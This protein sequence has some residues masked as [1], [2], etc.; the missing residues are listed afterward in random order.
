M[1]QTMKLFFVT[2][3]NQ[4]ISTQEGCIH[5][6]WVSRRRDVC[7]HH[8]LTC[9]LL[10]PTQHLQAVFLWCVGF[11]EKLNVAESG[12][13]WGTKHAACAS[14]AS[15]SL[16]IWTTT[17]PVCALSI[18]VNNSGVIQ[19]QQEQL[20]KV[21]GLNGKDVTAVR[22]ESLGLRLKKHT[23]RF[24]STAVTQWLTKGHKCV[25]T[26]YQ[27]T[28]RLKLAEAQRVLT[29]ASRASSCHFT[30]GTFPRTKKLRKI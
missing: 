3:P 7:C 13:F 22:W 5:A 19:A 8:R 1:L 23:E 15:V 16:E 11:D 14:V 18:R 20:Y 26:D 10:A 17:F 25:S 12:W 9:E 28:P 4:P 27:E 6:N 29:A 24:C 2:K 30:A 21:N